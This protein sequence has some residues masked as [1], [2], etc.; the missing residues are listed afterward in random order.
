MYPRLRGRRRRPALLS[1]D[2]IDAEDGGLSGDSLAWTVDREAAGTGEEVLLYGLAPG[3]YEVELTAHDATAQEATAESVLTILPLDIP[4]GDVPSLDGMCDDPAYATG[5]QLQLAPYGDG[6]QTTVHLLRSDNYLWAC[7][8]EMARGSEDPGAFAGI[9]VDADYSRDPLAQTDDYGF[10]VGEDGGYFSYAGDGAGGFDD[11]APGGVQ[12]QVS[13]NEHGWNAELRV[14]A[15]VLGRWDN[16]VGLSLGHYWA[17]VQQDDYA[18]PYAAVWNQPNTWAKTALSSLPQIDSLDP[19]SATAGGPNFTLEVVGENF[20]DGASLLWNGVA[21]SATYVD[22]SSLAVQIEA[23]QV[24]EGGTVGVAVSNPEPAVQVS[25]VVTFT[26]WPKTE[27]FI[28]LPLVIR[29]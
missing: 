23:D 26:V 20:V 14:D 10:F 12:A 21:Y 1:G 3:D 11:P 28:F 27:A 5:T 8:T 13:A 4:A 7:F 9:R 16:A 22:D 19:I 18:W 24:A 29:N 2:A 17:N 15:D 6:A 25:N